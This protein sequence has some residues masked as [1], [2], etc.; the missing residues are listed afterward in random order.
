MRFAY[1]DDLGALKEGTRAFLDGQNPP[2][3]LRREGGLELWPALEDMGLVDIA[4]SLPLAEAI[5]LFE[6]VGRTALPEP[7]ADTAVI[8]A[9]LLQ[10]LGA[11]GR[12]P[13]G[14]RVAICHADAPYANHADTADFI[15]LLDAQRVVWLARDAA[16][17]VSVR[18]IDPW[19]RL[20]SVTGQGDT[21]AEGD[22]ARE[23]CAYA[24]ALGATA[25]AAELLGLADRMIDLAVVYAGTRE[26]F[27]QAIGSF[28]AVKHLLA[29]A[30]VKLE[31]ARPVVYRASAALDSP[32]AVSHAKIAATDAA[33][34]AAE[35]AIQVHGGMG[36]T[37]EA[38]LH[39]FMKRAW[40]LAGVWGS[41]EQH[42]AVV[43]QAVLDGGIAIGPHNSFES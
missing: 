9:P 39:Y 32:V 18:S 11:A 19:R 22:A 4:A 30:R 33:L 27:G 5:A 25:A 35:Q 28:Q 31:F 34:F 13:Q 43:E 29:N 36:Y 15:L 41:R 20:F 6:E 1:S 23:A 12:R 16:K 7:L 21:L 24:A 37:Y 38:D 8:A 42:L 14:A 17:L 26:Q 10:S 2:E 3:R 40:A